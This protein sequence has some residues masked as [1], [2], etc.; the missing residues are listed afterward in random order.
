LYFFQVV[1]DDN[2]DRVLFCL[3]ELVYLYGEHLILVQYLPFVAE[4]V[5]LSKRKLTY[6]IEGGIIGSL[7]LLN[8]TLHLLSDASLMDNIQVGLQTPPC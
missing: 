7:A 8:H 5:A 3:K 1:G 4:I 6:S 2:A